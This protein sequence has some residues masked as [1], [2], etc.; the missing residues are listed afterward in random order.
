MV[1]LNVRTVAQQEL[2]TCIEAQATAIAPDDD[3]AALQKE[4]LLDDLAFLS[5]A[6]DE[7]LAARDQGAEDAESRFQDCC[8]RVKSVAI[9]LDLTKEIFADQDRLLKRQGLKIHL[10]P[11]AS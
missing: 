9:G 3:D 2:D 8:K 11:I 1:A 10:V 6:I 4:L 5:Q 7:M